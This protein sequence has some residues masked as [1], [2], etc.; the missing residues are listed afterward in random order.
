MQYESA[1]SPEAEASIHAAIR[2]SGYR[3]LVAIPKVSEKKGSIYIPDARRSD[4]ETASVV[5]KVL[6]LGPDAYSDKDRFP[7]GALCNAGDHVLIAPYAGV[8]LVVDEQEVRLI[9]DDSVMAVVT[10]PQ[11]VSRAYVR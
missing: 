5:V 1:L 6:A 9:N 11:K 10:E 7:T 8:R 2:P 4:E 3:V